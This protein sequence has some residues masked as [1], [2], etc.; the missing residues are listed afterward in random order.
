MECAEEN[1]HMDLEASLKSTRFLQLESCHSKRHHQC[2]RRSQVGL[3]QEHLKRVVPL[4]GHF[5]T[6]LSLKSKKQQ[7]IPKLLQHQTLQTFG[8]LRSLAY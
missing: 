3:P 7:N 8:S 5:V 4:L 6:F 2:R 1:H